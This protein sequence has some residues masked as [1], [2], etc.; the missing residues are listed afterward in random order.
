[1]SDE[2]PPKNWWEFASNWTWGGLV[3]TCAFVFIEKLVEQ[4]YGQA[5]FALILGLGIGAVALHSK[6]WLERTNPN[7]VYA[8]SIVAVLSIL[9]LPNIEERRWPF[10]A[11]FAPAPVSDADMA[12]ARKQQLDEDQKQI[13]DAQEAARKA[14]TAK[15]TTER[16][17]EAANRQIVALHSQLVQ[18]QQA[19]ARQI[20]AQ[21]P[22][23]APSGRSPAPEDQIPI[24]WQDDFQLNWYSGPK[25]AWI[26][27]SGQATALAHIKDAYII[28]DLTGHKEHLDVVNPTN[29]ADKWSID[30]IEPIVSGAPI[31]LIYEFQPP[32]SVSDFLSQWGAFEFHVIYAN[33]EYVQVYRQDYVN[34]K[35][36]RE[37]PGVIGPHV[38]KKS[39]DNPE[40]KK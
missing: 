5:L 31:M 30:Q 11:W 37:M 38:S 27:F 28:S 32:P 4:N 13:S 17:L 3:F 14:T 35:M 23:P 8:A 34:D 36:T 26:R 20:A 16:S 21:L 6:T 22:T 19:L 10:S 33:K 9:L 40:Q 29:F 39:I 25:M 18:A 7:W 2:K 15:E 12:N 24:R 1:M